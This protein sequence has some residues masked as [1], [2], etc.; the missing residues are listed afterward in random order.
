MVRN[1]PISIA[2]G[3]LEVIG[4]VCDDAGIFW[5]VAGPPS[6]P[7]LT[8]RMHERPNTIALTRKF[9]GDMSYLLMRKSRWKT[10]R[11]EQRGAG[12]F[13]SRGIDRPLLSGAARG[14]STACAAGDRK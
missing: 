11:S 9:M 3:L 14:T 4:R 6:R 13:V 1:V 2:K 7:K 5:R 8:Q 12:A 10:K